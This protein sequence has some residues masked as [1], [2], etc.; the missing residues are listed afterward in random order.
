[1]ILLFHS[2]YKRRWIDMIFMQ[3][4]HTINTVS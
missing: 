4:K 1:M 3:D 2:K